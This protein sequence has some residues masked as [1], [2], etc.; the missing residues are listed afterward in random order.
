MTL[1]SSFLVPEEEEDSGQ[2]LVRCKGAQSLYTN[3]WAAESETEAK[4]P[5]C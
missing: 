2:I 5:P 3:L 1:K 4:L